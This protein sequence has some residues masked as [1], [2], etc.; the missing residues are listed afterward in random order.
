MYCDKLYL[1]W[2]SA[3]NGV[4]LGGGLGDV[5]NQ[6]TLN[7]RDYWWRWFFDLSF[8]VF[9]II[10]LLN[11]IFGKIILGICSECVRYYHRYFRRSP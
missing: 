10:I 7:D 3:I 11:I 6:A 1:C 2:T 4:R 5:M 8:F 9:V